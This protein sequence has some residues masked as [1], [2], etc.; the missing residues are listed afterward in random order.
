[1]RC[2]E[3]VFQHLPGTERLVLHEVLAG[4]GH[5]EWKAPYGD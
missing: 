2:S 5:Q 1:V 3:V 4:V